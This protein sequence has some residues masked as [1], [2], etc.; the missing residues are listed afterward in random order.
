M[1]LAVPPNGVAS[2]PMSLPPKFAD[3]EGYRAVET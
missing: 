2:D 3:K 1:G